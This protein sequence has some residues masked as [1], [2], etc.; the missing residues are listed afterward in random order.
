MSALIR[1]L[2]TH[3][4][5]NWKNVEDLKKKLTLAFD[6]VTKLYKTNYKIPL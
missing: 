2:F 5:N 4:N 3:L 1:N 6:V